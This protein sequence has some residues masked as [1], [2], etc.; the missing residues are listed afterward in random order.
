M[1]NCVDGTYY[2]IYNSMQ[3]EH[4]EYSEEGSTVF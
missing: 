2:M 3:N 1:I 4:K